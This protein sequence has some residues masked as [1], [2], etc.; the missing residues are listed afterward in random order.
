MAARFVLCFSASADLRDGHEGAGT[1]GWCVAAASPV[2]VALSLAVAVCPGV[3]LT[4]AWWVGPSRS[5]S[6]WTPGVERWSS[7][8]R[9][10]VPTGR[11]QGWTAPASLLERWV[12]RSSRTLS[13]PEGALTVLRWRPWST[14]GRRLGSL[15][16]WL[17]SS[18]LRVSAPSYQLPDPRWFRRRSSPASLRLLQLLLCGASSTASG[19]A[20]VGAWEVE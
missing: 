11:V 8:R 1:P 17:G 15:G 9:P 13:L 18:R 10:L 19:C 16:P 6:A 5:W 2:W 14:A 7:V 3:G 12:G 20:A 4:M